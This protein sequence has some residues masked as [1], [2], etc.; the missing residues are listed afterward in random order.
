MSMVRWTVTIV[1]GVWIGMVLAALTL[2]LLAYGHASDALNDL[3]LGSL[4]P[5]VGNGELHEAPQ[6]LQ[7]L[8]E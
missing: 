4:G 6:P 1:I 3:E 2:M 5:S 8:P 7:H